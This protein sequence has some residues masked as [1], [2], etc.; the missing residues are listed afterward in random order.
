MKLRLKP[1]VD[2]R[3]DI[4]LNENVTEIFFYRNLMYALYVCIM[5]VCFE[6]KKYIF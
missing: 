6:A 4:S 3:K 2:K 1:V 5:Y